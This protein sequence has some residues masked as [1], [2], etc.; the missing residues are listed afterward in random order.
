MVLVMGGGLKFY[1]LQLKDLM[2]ILKVLLF[3]SSG[4][5]SSMTIETK[6]SVIQGCMI[7]SFDTSLE[8]SKNL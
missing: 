2:D 7:V 1:C 6:K 8:T 4:D 5:E 3:F